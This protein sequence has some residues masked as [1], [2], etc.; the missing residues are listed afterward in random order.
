MSDDEAVVAQ[1]G[2]FPV[3]V[4]AGKRYFFCTCGR[5]AR[6]PFC[7]GSHAGTSFQPIAFVPDASGTVNFCGCK[8]SDTLP[9]C[10]GSHNLL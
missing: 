8:S 6:Q 2:P 9:L 7:D 1:A 3:E 5:S 10:D 4:E